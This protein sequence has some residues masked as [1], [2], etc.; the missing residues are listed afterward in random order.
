[1]GFSTVKPGVRTQGR[2]AFKGHQENSQP[3]QEPRGL[4]WAKLFTEYEGRELL[5]K[6][7]SQNILLSYSSSQEVG[8]HTVYFTKGERG[9]KALH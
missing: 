7:T 4:H 6:Q 8:R 2:K 9:R 1:M 3:E 5:E